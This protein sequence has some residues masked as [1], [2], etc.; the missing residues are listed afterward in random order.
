MIIIVQWSELTHKVAR[1]PRRLAQD[2]LKT[3]DVSRPSRPSRGVFST[4]WANFLGVLA[5][6]RTWQTHKE[7]HLRTC[8]LNILIGLYFSHSMS[9]F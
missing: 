6:L 8:R 4:S 5:A 3:Q 2:S 7:M 1:T 9:P